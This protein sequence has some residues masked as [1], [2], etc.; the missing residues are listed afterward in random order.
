M[1]LNP[2]RWDK[3]LRGRNLKKVFRCGRYVKFFSSEIQKVFNGKKQMNDKISKKNRTQFAKN[4]L[5]WATQ[6]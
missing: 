4:F 6:I 3:P 1:I 5:N 2:K